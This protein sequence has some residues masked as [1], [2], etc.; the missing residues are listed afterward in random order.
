MAGRAYIFR[1]EDYL[2]QTVVPLVDF[3]GESFEKDY[4]GISVYMDE[5]DFMIGASIEDLEGAKLSGAVY[6]TPTPPILKLMPPVCATGGLIDLFG[7]PFIGTW[8]GPGIVNPAEGIFRD[9]CTR[10]E[11]TSSRQPTPWL[12]SLW[13]RTWSSETTLKVCFFL[14]SSFRFFICHFAIIIV[15][16]TCL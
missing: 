9:R 5:T 3:T 15:I 2:W 10:P 12:W 4:Y 8:S 13:A 7:Y 6:V 16:A 14:N 1:A 11:W